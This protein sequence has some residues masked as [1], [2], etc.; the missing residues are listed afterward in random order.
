MPLRLITVV[1][2]CLM[3]SGCYCMPDEGDSTKASEYIDGCWA[4]AKKTH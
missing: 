2:M 4:E 1:C 3:L